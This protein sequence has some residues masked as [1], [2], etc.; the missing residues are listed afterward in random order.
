MIVNCVSIGREENSLNITNINILIRFNKTRDIIPSGTRVLSILLTTAATGASVKRVNYK[1]KILGSSQAASYARRW[2]LWSEWKWWRGYQE[3]AFPFTCCPMNRE[4]SWKEK[5]HRKKKW[6]LLY[7]IYEQNFGVWSVKS[8]LALS[9]Q[10]SL[11]YRNQTID[12]QRK[13]GTSVMKELM[14][15]YLHVFIEI[16]SLIMTK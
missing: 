6:I 15:C 4:Y 5:P 7:I 1:P 10:G 12:F 8:V 3:I 2:A 14:L 13:S 11:S 9:R 16:Y